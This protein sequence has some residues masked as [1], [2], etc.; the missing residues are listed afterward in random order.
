M[1]RPLA[2]LVRRAKRFC[3]DRPQLKRR[4]KRLGYAGLEWLGHGLGPGLD[5]GPRLLGYHTVGDGE[6][7]L[8]VSAAQFRGQLEWLLRRKFHICTLRQ[9]AAH[10]RTGQRIAPRTVVLSFDDGFRSLSDRVAPVLAEYGLTA[11]VFVVTDYVGATNAFDEP[12]RQGPEL[13]L[14]SWNELE[15]LQRSGWDIQAHGRR[16]LPMV[17][18]DS[19]V[20]EEEAAGSKLILERRL[21]RPVDFFSYPYGA[22]DLTA[23]D[24]LRRAG[25]LGA[26]TCRSGI[27]PTRPDQDWFRLPRT[28]VDGLVSPGYFSAVFRRG[29]LRLSAA[30]RW[31]QGPACAQECPFDELDKLTPMPPLQA[32]PA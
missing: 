3:V 10:V 22:F 14:L 23:V 12:F 17:Q 13:P 24:V 5:G 30:D 21:G 1:M 27:L 9:W 16:H 2:P 18:L 29:F 7:D 20:L 15:A 6:N 31:L 25:Y 19:D 26:V 4:V 8:S 32:T 11:T 28:L